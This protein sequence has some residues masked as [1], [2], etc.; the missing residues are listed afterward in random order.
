M[1]RL[2]NK[3]AIVTGGSSGIGLAAARLFAS[4]GARVV[5]FARNAE[6]LAEA[7]A[8]VGPNAVGVRGDVTRP[9]DLQGLYAQTHERF[10]GVDVLF[11]N[12]A[13]VKL[14][15]IADTPED[16]FGEIVG[17]NMKGAFDTLRLGIPILSKGAS[18]I[19]TTSWLNR[20]GFAGSS[21]VAMTKAALRALVRVA[22]AELGPRGIRVNALCPGAIQTPM[23]GKLGLSPEVLAAAG[24]DITAQIP[25]GRW[26]TPEELAQAALFL[27]G[28]E[29]AYL[30]GMELAVDGGL[31]QS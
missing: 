24:A 21:V 15:P 9:G 10:G 5:L 6:R 20:M 8:S 13:V 16:L 2:K 1:V 23:W 27:A 17:I 22:A 29:S 3:T 19:V 28:P 26:G 25:L 14:S 7:V 4:E 30:N 12:A 18:V 11:A 31:R